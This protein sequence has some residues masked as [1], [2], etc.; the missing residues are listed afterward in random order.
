MLQLT[1]TITQLTKIYRNLFPLK[2]ERFLSHLHH[3]FSARLEVGV[4]DTKANSAKASHMF[5][6]FLPSQIPCMFR[7]DLPHKIL[8]GICR[9]TLNVKKKSL[10]LLEPF[11]VQKIVGGSLL[12][13]VSSSSICKTITRPAHNSKAARSLGRNP[14]YIQYSSWSFYALFIHL[15]LVLQW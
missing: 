7:A 3:Y 6:L 13:S 15:F 5:P 8:R 12:K 10:I 4:W 11:W 14:L 2:S 9:K 1:I